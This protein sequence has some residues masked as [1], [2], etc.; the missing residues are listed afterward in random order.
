[1]ALDAVT[2]N[3]EI[4]GEAAR[5]IPEPLRERYPLIPWRRVVGLRNIVIHQYF[6]V[7]P[8]IIWTI[9]TQQLPELKPLLQ[10]MLRDLE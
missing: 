5:Q 9:A 3:L 6:A 2:R 1:M 10:T 7:D 4:I 8:N